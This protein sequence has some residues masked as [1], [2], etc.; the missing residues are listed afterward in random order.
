MVLKTRTEKEE[1]SSEKGQAVG[2]NE[3]SLKR[4]PTCFNV[5]FGD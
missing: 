1:K 3:N 5:G 4:A 2:R